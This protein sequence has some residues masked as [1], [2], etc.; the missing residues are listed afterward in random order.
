[1]A[2]TYLSHSRAIMA[3]GLPLIGSHLAGMMLHVTDTVLMGR[4]GVAELA[5]VTL[6]GS[7]FFIVFILG[8]G[9]AQALMPLVAVAV[10]KGDETEVR[11]DTRMALWLSLG[12]GLVSYPVF[13]T[14]GSWLLAMGQEPQVAQLAQDFL[15]IAGPGM[16]PALLVMALKSYL[17]ALGR[18]Q[19][20]LW[21]TLG[22]VLV[23]LALGWM[24]IFGNW[25]APELGVRGAALATLL[26]QWVTFAIM[27][28]YAHFQPALRRFGL[29][30]RFWRIDGA[31]LGRVFRLGWPIGI[32]GLAES[33]LFAGA[34][35][36]M[37]W[38]ST[39]ALAAHGIA[40]QVAALAFM[41]HL[42]LSNAATVL[43][44][45]ASGA[46]D[47]RGLRQIA[48]AAIGLSLVLCA[49]GIVIFISAPVA[50]IALFLDTTKPESPQILA[51]GTRLLVL[52]ALFQLGDAM[53]VMA[54]GLL[55]AIRDTRVPMWAAAFSYW[56]VGIPASAIL[57]FYFDLGAEGIWL[58]LCIGLLFASTSLMAR[59]WMRA[60]REA[61]A[62]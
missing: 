37:G 22:G 61:L 44:G 14:S 30:N 16:V 42:G 54:L 39:E 40:M 33:G 56:G 51:L 45:R 26:V 21:V 12:F 3:L 38:V 4:Y 10:G 32:T 35:L 62:A 55:R 41:V 6:A 15:R 31:A 47:V 58:G 1:M 49:I 36:M 28:V 27:A 2:Q 9:F 53:Q 59:F 48:F 8:S 43:A 19:V 18:T 34:S 23:N 60:P 20:V 17:S 29:F 7:C 11:R 50:I 46:G 25:G 57:G 24:L 13:W 52:A 5:A